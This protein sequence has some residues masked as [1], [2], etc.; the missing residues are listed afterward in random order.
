MEDTIAYIILFAIGLGVLYAYQYRRLR[1]R[2][3]PLS[4]QVY[5]ECVLKVLVVKQH[6]KIQSI[7][8][9]IIARKELTIKSVSAELIGKSRDFNHFDFSEENSE[10]TLPLSLRKNKY[11]DV[12]IPFDDL[13]KN[14]ISLEIPF[15]TFRFVFENLAG[16]KFKTHE[17]A[18]NKNWTIYR[19]DS[20][21]YN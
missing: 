9:R 13:K 18:F 17:F 6:G 3:M 5:P 7:V 19:P 1:P 14:L 20:G 21:K 10:I 2:Q 4:V 15:R 11:T 16:K 12:K 8:I